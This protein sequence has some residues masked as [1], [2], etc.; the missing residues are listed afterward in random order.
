[1]PQPELQR[2][3]QLGIIKVK[4]DDG[5][6]NRKAAYD[7]MNTLLDTCLDRLQPHDLIA[8]VVDGISD[9]VRGAALRTLAILKLNGSL[10][11]RV[12]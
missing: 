1:M 8:R 7:C 3:L 6:E 11:V 4:V 5:A 2:E 9:K 12:K 10:S